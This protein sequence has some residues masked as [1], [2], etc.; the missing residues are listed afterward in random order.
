MFVFKQ[1]QY[2][3]N[4]AFFILGIIEFYT[5]KVCEMFVYKHTE[6]IE[7]L[8]VK[9]SRIFSIKNAKVSGYYFYI[10]LNILGDFQICISVPLKIRILKQNQTQFQRNYM[11]K[12]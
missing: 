2:P 1:K 4:F 12:L 11:Q 9:N 8:R 7:T 6:T 3:K 10:N 5:R